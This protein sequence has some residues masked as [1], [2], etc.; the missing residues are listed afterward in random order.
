MSHAA[1]NWAIKQ[2]GISPASKLVL[3]HLCDR[4]HP[5]HGCFPSQAT[6]AHDCEMSRRSVNDHLDRLENAGLIRRIRQLDER[7]KRQKSTRYILAF[8]DDFEQDD[9]GPCAKSAHGSKEEQSSEPR[10]KSAHGAVCK[11]TSKPCANSRKS[12]VQNLHTNSVKE[13]V[14]EQRARAETIRQQRAKAIREGQ[15]WVGRH[16]SPSAA[17]E[18][19][20]LQLVTAEQCRAA[21]VQL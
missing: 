21:G 6:L 14:I 12:R 13:P 10:A 7:T 11:S 9:D 4:F 19:V 17:R 18:L 20:D 3:W 15:S 1:T 16:I 8:E 2:R 5:D